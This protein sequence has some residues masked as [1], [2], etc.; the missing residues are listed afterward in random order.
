VEQCTPYGGLW[1]CTTGCVQQ[2]LC[3]WSP[4]AHLSRAAACMLGLLRHSLLMPRAGDKA[5]P[6]KGEAGA[7]APCCP[8][9]RQ[10]AFATRTGDG[11]LGSANVKPPDQP[12]TPPPYWY[13][14][15]PAM[16]DRPMCT[17]KPPAFDASP[18]S[19]PQI[20]LAEEQQSFK[21]L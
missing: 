1:L 4:I 10:L 6:A 12:S 2:A 5:T 3:G 19:T 15:N 16:Q 7:P 21:P 11:E 14:R 17:R 9:Y 8:C 20:G 13:G 18:R